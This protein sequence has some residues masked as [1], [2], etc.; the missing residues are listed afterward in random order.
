MK[1]G[2]RDSEIARA[3]ML[4]RQIEEVLP[5]LQNVV[6]TLRAT[7]LEEKDTARD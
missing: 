2:K 3:E 4:T 1:W 5:Q 6:D 7:L